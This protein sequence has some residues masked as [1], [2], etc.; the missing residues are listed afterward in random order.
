MADDA[1]KPEEMPHF[2]PGIAQPA[3]KPVPVPD[4]ER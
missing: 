4:P 1:W 2:P 3:S